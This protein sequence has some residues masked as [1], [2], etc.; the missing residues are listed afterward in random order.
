MSGDPAPTNAYVTLSQACQSGGNEYFLPHVIGRRMWELWTV[1]NLCASDPQMALVC[2]GVG[3]GGHDAHFWSPT[4]DQGKA[5]I[6]MATSRSPSSLYPK[7]LETE[8][9]FL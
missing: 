7:S 1:E 3:P 4:S 6:S 5:C 8:E 9:P 2:P